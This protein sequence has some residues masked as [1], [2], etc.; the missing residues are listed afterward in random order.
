MKIAYL[1][2]GVIGGL[3]GKNYELNDTDVRNEI[4]KCT[5]STHKF[6]HTNDAEIDYFIFSW[7][8]DLH[9]VYI[10]AYKPKRIITTEQIIFDMPDHY[11]EYDIHPRIQAHYARWYGAKEVH[12]LMLDYK[13]KHNIQY[14]LVINARLDLCYHNTIDLQLLNPKQFHIAQPV[15]L[16]SYNWPHTGEMIDH[17]FASSEETMYDISKLFD[18]L[19]EYTKP[20]QCPRWKLI[21]NHFLIVWHLN[22][23]GLL[24]TNN[25]NESLTTV[26]AGYDSNVDYHIFR[27][28]NLTKEELL[29]YNEKL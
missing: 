21:S 19:N 12:N 27:Y 15:N 18:Y 14:D 25:I 20:D 28:K 9:D 8:P 10:N 1:M 23:L 16:T 5:A 22:K 6:L 7:E 4:V 2:N 26:D 17:F 24:T 29:E 13:I 3:S 11:K